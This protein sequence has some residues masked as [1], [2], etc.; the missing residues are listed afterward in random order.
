MKEMPPC[1]IGQNFNAM[2]PLDDTG[3]LSLD[4][5]EQ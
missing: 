1:F 2:E 4:P 5:V 3:P